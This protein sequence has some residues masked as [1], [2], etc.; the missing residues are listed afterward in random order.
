MRLFSKKHR[1]TVP[2]NM[3][4]LIKLTDSMTIGYIGKRS[5]CSGKRYYK[6]GACECTY[7]EKEVIL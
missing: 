3:F 2:D 1:N 5:W 6:N 7:T 4:R